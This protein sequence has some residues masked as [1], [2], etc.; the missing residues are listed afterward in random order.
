MDILTWTYWYSYGEYRRHWLI[1]HNNYSIIW[2][3][4]KSII[5]KQVV[6]IDTSN[7][8]LIMIMAYYR[9]AS[10]CTHKVS[11]WLAATLK[12]TGTRHHPNILSRLQMYLIIFQ[13][14][15]PQMLLM[16]ILIC[17]P[18]LLLQGV[19]KDIASDNNYKPHVT[20]IIGN[21]PSQQNPY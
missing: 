16:T 7:S 3:I 15:L 13:V 9:L 17:P 2:T 10:W 20:W 14:E 6:A 18:S 21:L 11:I 5:N 19:K 4:T 12:I 1:E 8:G